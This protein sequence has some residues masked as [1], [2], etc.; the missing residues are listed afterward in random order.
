MRDCHGAGNVL[1]LDFSHIGISVLMLYYSFA[2]ILS[3]SS[4][5][6]LSCVRLFVTP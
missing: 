4:A 1:Y 3:F 2:H 5:Q 6:L